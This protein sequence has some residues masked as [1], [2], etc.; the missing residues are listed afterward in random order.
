MINVSMKANN[1]PATL[2]LRVYTQKNFAAGFFDKNSFSCS[3][4]LSSC[5][6]R[7]GGKTKAS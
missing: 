3:T 5:F 2:S 1:F 6:G 4:T 7:F